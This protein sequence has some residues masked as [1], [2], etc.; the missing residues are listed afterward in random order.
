MWNNSCKVLSTLSATQLGD[1]VHATYKITKHTQ[2]T[3]ELTHLDFWHLIDLNTK[4]FTLSR[5]P[6]LTRRAACLLHQKQWKQE[7][8]RRGSGRCPVGLRLCRPV[9]LHT[10]DRHVWKA[11]EASGWGHQEGVRRGQPL[12]TPQGS[13]SVW[14]ECKFL[15]YQQ[16]A[17]S[18]ED[19]QFS[20]Q[21]SHGNAWEDQ[22]WETVDLFINLGCSD[23]EW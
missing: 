3:K 17:A 11:W 19:R 15:H 8:P 10:G 18:D 1:W 16:G 9:V 5:R 7:G 20:P 2:S 4:V 23:S 22:P 14:G 12:T 13:P 6:I 21:R